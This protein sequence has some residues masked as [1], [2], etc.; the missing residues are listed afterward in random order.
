MSQI[1]HSVIFVAVAGIVANGPS[2]L[3][4]QAREPSAAGY[5]AVQCPSCAEWNKP[6][7]PVRLFGNTYYVGTRGLGAILITSSQGHV[8]ID[9]GLPESAPLIQASIRSLGLRVE[10][11]KLILNSHPHYDH[12]GGIAAVEHASG[13]IVAASP[14]A[15]A[16]MRHGW[17]GPDDPQYG[18]ALPYP[19]VDSVRVIAD[20]DTLRAGAVTVTAHFT[21]GHTPGGTSWSWRSC[22]NGQCL[23]F[24]YADSQTPIS[25]NGFS[26]TRSASY[27]T[28][29]ADFERGFAVLDGLR[30]DVLLTPHPRAS[31]LWERLAARDRGELDALRRADGCRRYVAA[32][33]EAL[34]ERVIAE[35]LPR[36]SSG[37]GVTLE[38]ADADSGVAAE[39]ARIMVTGRGAIDRFFGDPFVRPFTIRVFPNRSTLSTHWGLSWGVANLQTECWM[40]ASGVAGELALLSPRVWKTDACEHDIADTAATRR[41]L[42]HELVHVYHGQHNPRPTFDGMDDLGWFVEGLAVLASGQLESEHRDDARQAIAAGKAPGRLADAWSGRWRY[43]VAGSLVGYVDRTWS[44]GIVRAMLADTTQAALLSRLGVTEADLIAHWRTATQP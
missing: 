1:R 21:P 10:D 29:M 25:A 8:L 30:C 36:R 20:G 18:V 16:V 12:A 13:A 6:T 7:P 3:R 5:S 14:S 31:Q 35:V 26:F 11:I 42:W 43:G 32:A 4:A 34:D 41:V 38:F 37:D 33:R 19:P 39:M 27:P 22:E 28:A 40:V 9:G 15:A 24:V 2:R 44:R 23:D 17:S